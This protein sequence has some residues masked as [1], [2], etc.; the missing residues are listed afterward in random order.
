MADQRET[1]HLVAHGMEKAR[2][3]Q[4]GLGEQ[5]KT[6]FAY[7][8]PRIDFL[9]ET[10]DIYPNT[11]NAQAE[12]EREA[13][14]RGLEIIHRNNDVANIINGPEYRSLLRRQKHQK[15]PCA[16][17]VCFCIDGRLPRIHLVGLIAGATETMAGIQTTRRSKIDGRLELTS[18]TLD[19]SI[20]SKPTKED[21]QLLEIT[22]AHDDCGAM[23]KRQADQQQNGTPFGSDDLILENLDLFGDSIEAM[24]RK[25]NNAATSMGRETLEKVGIRMV[26]FPERM[27]LFAGYGDNTGNTLS[28]FDIAMELSQKYPE[29]D[30]KYKDNFEKLEIF[31]EKE[32][33]LT[34]F[35]DKLFGDPNFN[36]QISE[37]LQTIEEL[38]GLTPEQAQTYRYLM[39]RIT[40]L[41]ILSGTHRARETDHKYHVDHPFAHHNESYMALTIDDGLNVTVGQFDPE[42]QVFGAAVASAAEATEHVKVENVLLDR[43][44][45]VVYPRILFISAGVAEDSK[46]ESIKQARAKLARDFNSIISNRDILRLIRTGKIVPIPVI[47]KNRSAQII[48]VPNLAL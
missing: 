23:K 42:V 18:T 44:T 15:G 39:A 16:I 20:A 12:V 40:A 37:S 13:F 41:N 26:Y 27:A 33:D 30:S 10:A 32:T 29:Y 28:T 31:L 3:P 7:F 11:D 35:V 9:P 25:Y 6:Y 21:A 46:E 22:I 36:Q 43:R 24:R 5:L 14:K 19:Q 8:Y 17:G 48:E 38:H 45:D 1:G 2:I 47:I 4:N 34:D